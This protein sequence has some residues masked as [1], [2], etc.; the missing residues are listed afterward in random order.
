M[1]YQV[2]NKV[3]ELTLHNMNRE[4]FTLDQVKGKRYML[5]FMRFAACPFCQLRIHQ[6]ISNW[7][8][9]DENFTVLAVFD[10]PLDNL[11]KHC[12]HQLAPF[13]ILA[14]ESGVYYQKF[15]IKHSITGLLKAMFFRMPTL[16][17][18]MFS[19][20]YFPSSIQGKMTTLPTDI[21]VNEQGIIE[22][23]YSGKDSGDH[24]PLDRVKA[25]AC[26]QKKLRV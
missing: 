22:S 20:G 11:Q 18:A 26:L 1:S 8:E 3:T 7:Q 21:L 6:L 12:E 9:F 4:K 10:S 16:L 25:F 2:G 19:K 13:Q 23:I 5:S 24:L 15:A 14:D 17:T